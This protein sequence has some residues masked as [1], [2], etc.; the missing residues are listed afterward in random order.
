MMA[1]LFKY[2]AVV[3][4][5]V[6][7][8]CHQQRDTLKL[9]VQADERTMYLLITAFPCIAERSSEDWVTAWESTGKVPCEG[10]REAQSQLC[11]E[12]D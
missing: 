11:W 10:K 3:Y 6:L 7:P 2:S 5:S 9:G 12:E 1:L 4:L 8:Y